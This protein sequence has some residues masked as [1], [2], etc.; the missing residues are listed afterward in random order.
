[1]VMGWRRDQGTRISRMAVSFLKTLFA[2]LYYMVP[3]GVLFDTG[4][5]LEEHEL[6]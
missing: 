5:M 3:Y 6:R 2:S 4:T 1:M